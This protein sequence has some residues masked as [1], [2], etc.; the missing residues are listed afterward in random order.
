EI[1]LS[2][3]NDEFHYLYPDAFIAS[4]MDAQNSLIKGYDPAY[5]PL[6]KIETDSQVR[7]VEEKIVTAALSAN[8]IT[9]NEAERFITTIRFTLPQLQLMEL[10]NRASYSLF[11][12]APSALLKD[13]QQSPPKASFLAGL[14]E[15]LRDALIYPAQAICGACFD[16]LLC[17]QFGTPGPGLIIFRIACY[18]TG[19]LYGQGCL[20]FCTGSPAI[21]D[22]ETGICGCA[23]EVE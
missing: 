9:K 12:G 21:Y 2:L 6:S 11:K 14:L 15:K 1:I 22:P 8:I 18:C 20:D 5:V 17:Y 13:S 4:L 10:K 7:F 16:V 19:C 3:T 23:V